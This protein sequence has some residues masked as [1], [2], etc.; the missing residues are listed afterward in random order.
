MGHPIK[1]QDLT[2][3]H[4]SIRK[5]LLTAFEASLD[6]SA[7]IQGKPVAAFEKEFAAYT[8]STHCL[9]VANGTDAL[10]LLLEAW[11][12]GHGHEVIVPSMTFAATGEAPARQGATPL[13]ADV[14]D[15]TLCLNLDGIKDAYGRRKNTVKAVIFVHLYGRA[16]DLSAIRRW[17]DD[18]G[19]YLIEDCAQAHGAR[20]DGVHVGNVG[21]G[22][23]F[24][25]YPGKNL[26]ALGDGGAIITESSSLHERIRL[27]RDHGRT[28]KYTHV[29]IGRNSRL[30][31]LQASFLSVKLK[32]LDRWNDARR[33]LA[34][35]YRQRL[36][37][38]KSL[39]LL[40]PTVDEQSHG[41]HQFV[42]RVNG[43]HQRRDAL[44]A[45]LGD[46]AIETGIHYPIPLHQQPAFQCWSHQLEL[47]VSAAAADDILS[48]PMDPLMTLA[49]ADEVCE[50][51]SSFFQ[52]GPS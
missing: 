16:C 45:H 30:D 10:E 33:A 50:R 7:F 5:E 26:G 47:P 20:L 32:H 3:L 11:G 49:E 36:A 34:A 29:T 18:Q 22:A 28:E 17:C 41:Y 8:G 52:E 39:R 44:R 6:S 42:I 40:A 37:P 13:L 19:I 14:D 21:H 2:R 23:T 38:L 48:L 35:R 24:S 31:A 25:F 4:H 43:G 15:S 9:G 51:I 1:Q 46:R 27:L 12:V